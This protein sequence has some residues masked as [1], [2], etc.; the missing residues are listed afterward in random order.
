MSGELSTS[1]SANFIA[2]IL[3]LA[4]M[5]VLYV[6]AA[7]HGH[8]SALL[9]GRNASTASCFWFYF[10]TVVCLTLAYADLESSHLFAHGN[11]FIDAGLD[12][13]GDLGS[14]F[15]LAAAWAYSR[16]NEFSVTSTLRTLAIAAGLLMIWYLA[17]RAMAPPGLFYLLLQEAPGIVLAV[18]STV[19]LGWVFFARWGGWVGGLYLLARVGYGVLQLPANLRVFIGDYLKDGGASLD[20]SFSWLA[21][22]KVVLAIVFLSLLCRSH[23]AGIATDEPQYAPE[24]PVHLTEPVWK[25]LLRDLAI[26]FAM[27]LAV[28]VIKMLI[29]TGCGHVT[30]CF[31]HH[32]APK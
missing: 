24:E 13:L 17:W 26:A 14:L 22:G 31:W 3:I 29:E 30:W 5:L 6:H 19:T 4:A 18:L 25:G 27:A 12:T 32:N 10:A 23:Q 20:V 2:L 1:I 16:A 9:Y 28:E 15:T 7:W 11:K 21:G 8:P